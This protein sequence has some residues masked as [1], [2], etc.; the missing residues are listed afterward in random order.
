M[1]E[2]LFSVIVPTYGRPEF[3]ADAVE[4]VLAQSVGDLECVVVDDASPVP[5]DLPDDPRVR[6]VRRT[7]NG[8]A[9]AAR[10]TGLRE[11]RGRYVTFLDDDDVYTSD[12]LALAL[13]GLARAPIAICWSG[14]LGA[15]QDSV[16][17]KRRLNGSI[18]D[19]VLDRPIPHVGA[20]ALQR[21]LAPRFDERYRVTE[22]IEWWLRLTQAAP[23]ATVPRVGYLLRHHPGSR[24]TSRL[25]ER[26]R[27]RLL[28]LQSHDWYFATHP[29][30]AAY[31]WKRLGGIA[32]RCGDHALARLAFRR[33][34]LLRPDV[35]T[36]WHLA[37]ALRPSPTRIPVAM[38]RSGQ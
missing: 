29:R 25:A 14:H 9:A 20:C 34:F 18:H 31:H 10:N 12:R 19:V 22:D 38:P 37:R 17:W 21:H 23:V 30:A 4:A 33:S 1:A 13:E 15:P 32:L 8:G 36:A 27:C 7:E 28:L 16:A 26:L 24:L 2:P 3:L 35:G 6:L 5:P 11:A